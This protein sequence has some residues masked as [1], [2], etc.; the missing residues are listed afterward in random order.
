MVLAGTAGRKLKVFEETE[1]SDWRNVE[2]QRHQEW[3]M[4]AIAAGRK[5]NGLK[6]LKEVIEERW[7]NN[8]IWNRAG[9]CCG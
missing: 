9:K 8:D 3:K 5:L 6:K 4:L 7:N 1:G 2:Q